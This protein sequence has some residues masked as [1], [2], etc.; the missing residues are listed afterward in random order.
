[1]NGRG[2]S[3]VSVNWGIWIGISHRC[4]DIWVSAERLGTLGMLRGVDMAIFVIA[5]KELLQIDYAPGI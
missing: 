4:I 5:E 1:M 3:G 2:E